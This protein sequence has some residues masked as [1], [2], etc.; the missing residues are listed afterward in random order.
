MAFKP[1][2]GYGDVFSYGVSQ[3]RADGWELARLS[4]SV[5]KKAIDQLVFT[6]FGNQSKDAFGVGGGGTFT[7]PI[8]KSWGQPGTVSPLVSGT[9]IG[10]GTFQTDSVSMSMYEYGTA[11]G[12][13]TLGDWISSLP[14]RENLVSVMGEHIGRMINWLDYDIAANT[15]WSI[16][17]PAAGSYSSLLG[18][19]R[20]KV[21]TSYGEL[22]YGM[23]ALTYDL[24][25]SSLVTPLNSRG[26][27]AIVGNSRTFRH[28]K[29][30]SVFQNQMLYSGM[31]GI[32]YQVLG[33]FEKFI[34]VE[35]EE[36]T[37]NG[38]SFVYGLNSFGYGFG[39]LPQLTY[40]PDFGQDAGRLQVWKVLFYRGQGPIW[41]NKGTS[42]ICL[43]T[44]TSAYNYGTLG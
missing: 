9:A 13:E 5:M 16:E 22:G 2:A 28:L 44:N 7:T 15:P 37:G 26:M 8:I 21:G 20:Q 40:Y 14:I 31:Q 32:N 41:R 11:I 34:F 6:R 35:T 36:Q 4:G 38:T 3:V 23:L 42:L 17:S 24:L 18:T 29:T 27:Y 12:W 33:E 1:S 25:K 19:N 39:K 43:R 30:G 10:I